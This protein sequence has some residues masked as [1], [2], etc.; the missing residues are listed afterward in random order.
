VPSIAGK[1]YHQGILFSAIRNSAGNGDK[2]NTSGAGLIQL[3][4][5]EEIQGASILGQWIA[6]NLTQSNW[7]LE[8]TRDAFNP[9]YPRKIPSVVG[10]DAP[11]GF[12]QWDGQI[13]SLGKTGI[14]QMNNQ[15]SLR[16]DSKI[17]NFA[18]EDIE[19][20]NFNVTYGGF[21]RYN[22]QFLFSYIDNGSGENSQNR[23]LSYNYEEKSWAIFNLRLSVFGQTDIGQSLTWN[24]IDETIKDSWARWDTTEEL[25]NE[26]GQTESVQ[27]TLAGDTLGF[28]YELNQDFDDYF[29]PI[30]AITQAAQ[31]VVTVAAT[32]FDVGDQV[33]I[34]NVTDM[35]EINNFDP[36]DDELEGNFYTVIAATS[37]S[38][39]LDVDST[40]FTAYAA[41]GGNLSKVISFSAKTNPFNP[42]RD[43]GRKCYI[44][45]VEF[46][47][48]STSGNLFV[49]VLADE[50]QTP[51]RENVQ[52]SPYDLSKDKN[53]IEMSVNHEADFFSFVFRHESAAKGIKITSVRI[54]AMPGGKTSG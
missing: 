47:I 24:Q 28:I 44:S 5:Y 11:F 1:V 45:M 9:Y 16:I 29:E 13:I 34:E 30:S 14:L 27:K 40:N 42:Y 54:H 46:L 25:W 51:I 33:V 35:I 15:Q 6:L 43:Q 31:A 17:P 39:T 21:D 20:L 37:T 19:P 52:L 48:N 41:G 18:R 2:F 53:W 36:E 7:T 23:V 38:I 26:I 32:N 49:D 22:S 8:K 4:T 12:A 10:T 3:D 50:E